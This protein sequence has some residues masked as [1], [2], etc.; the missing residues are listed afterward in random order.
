MSRGLDK[1]PLLSLLAAVRSYGCSFLV[2]HF[3]N[4]VDHGLR[5]VEL[6]IFRAFAGEDL[7]SVRRQSEPARLGQRALPLIFEVLRRVRRLTLQVADTV[8]SGGEHA[9]G[10]RA[11]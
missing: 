2:I 8:V 3:A 11:E 1:V 10:A 7:F 9:D 6:D 4:G 5:L